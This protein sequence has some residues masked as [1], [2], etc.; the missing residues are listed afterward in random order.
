MLTEFLLQRP[1]LAALARPERVADAGR[2]ALKAESSQS[3]IP[4]S[5][6][7]LE[8][9]SGAQ[10]ALQEA[11]ISRPEVMGS[12]PAE[13][14]SSDNK[15]S[16]TQKELTPD[17]Q[18]KVE[19]LKKI[20]Q[21]VRTHE[22]AHLSAAG[23]YA[24]GGAHYDYAAGPDGNRYAVAGHVNLDTGREASPEATIQKAQIVRKA[25]LAPANPSSSDRQIAASMTQMATEARQ[26]MLQEV[27]GSGANSSHTATSE[28]ADASPSSSSEEPTQP[29]VVRHSGIQAYQATQRLE[30]SIPAF[31]WFA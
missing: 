14:D 26:E 31:S 13:K 20:D 17:D 16:S 3:A 9:S 18:R 24:R 12:Q 5:A 23:G 29:P 22:Q 15:N 27:R 6:Y 25:A 4:S 1:T 21:E 7:Q 8:L 30:F 11:Q 19:E 10:K 28:S 2:V